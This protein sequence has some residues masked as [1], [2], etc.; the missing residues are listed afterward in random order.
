MDNRLTKIAGGLVGAGLVSAL[1]ATVVGKF[2]RNWATTSDLPVRNLGWDS[3]TPGFAS[4]LAMVVGVAVFLALVVG[5]AYRRWIVAVGIA[6][7]GVLMLLTLPAL[8][9]YY[10]VMTTA[11][12]AAQQV[13]SALVAWVCALSGAVATGVGALVLAVGRRSAGWRSIALGAVVALVAVVLT[14]S[15]LMRAAD[16]DRFVDATTAASVDPG[17]IPAAVGTAERFS[18]HVDG[19]VVRAGGAGFVVQAPDG[20]RAF[21]AAGQERW[22]YLHIG[23]P[24]W[25]PMFLGVF[26]AGATVVLG[27]D[28][29]AHLAGE[30]VGLD[31]VTGAVLWRS[32]RSGLIRTVDDADAERE[33]WYLVIANGSELTR[34]DT[35]T[36]KE[37][38]HS[39]IPHP[40][41][42]VPFDTRI[43]IGYFSGEAQT[44]GV[45]MRYV[46]LDPQTGAIRFDIPVG[47]YRW[48]DGVGWPQRINPRHA[49]DDGT[50][51]VDADGRPRYVNGMSGVL[52]PFGQDDLIEARGS[53]EFLTRTEH[54][55][56]IRSSDDGRVRCTIP[57]DAVVTSAGWLEDQVLL[58]HGDRISA[59][60]RSDC[61]AQ[62]ERQAPRG[63]I[64]VAPGVVLVVGAV[65]QGAV[66]VT[67]YV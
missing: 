19:A 44:T 35:R 50:V 18:L 6:S 11:Y 59:Y 61:A 28:S 9:R 67:G 40:H 54:A 53:A 20:V 17:P 22:H 8:P 33:P 64:L 39:T 48:T 3:G 2:S 5:L 21:D 46:S 38:W 24:P 63:D 51:F 7:V 37:L 26:D 27:L 65:D 58:G 34:I 42:Y 31:A 45:D 41:M 12:E 16:A 36:G 49:G 30:V 1:A 14:T 47:V 60:R 62:V 4:G 66:T 56:A 57:T 32:A 29:G 23:Q 52:T 15:L 25:H 13:P 10:H 55:V 43:G